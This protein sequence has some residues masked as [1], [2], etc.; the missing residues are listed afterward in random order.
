[1]QKYHSFTFYTQ[2]FQNVK[3]KIDQKKGPIL[4][5]TLTLSQDLEMLQWCLT[6]D[7]M[8]KWWRNL[9]E[10]FLIDRKHCIFDVFEKYGI[11]WVN[12]LMQ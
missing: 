11:E 6:H 3:L 10:K 1:M 5:Q 7:T 12:I 4:L 2:M 8:V 9:L